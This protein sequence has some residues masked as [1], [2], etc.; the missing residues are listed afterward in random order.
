MGS[1]SA[2]GALNDPNCSPKGL[3]A[4]V[5]VYFSII[6]I[7]SPIS[8]IF[9]EP[10]MLSLLSILLVLSRRVSNVLNLLNLL[11]ATNAT[12]ASNASISQRK[13]I[14]SGYSRDLTFVVTGT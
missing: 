11:N 7:R 2:E 6:V 3:Q 9:E 12:N 10:R 4:H 8:W 5:Q 13:S 14:L 1:Q